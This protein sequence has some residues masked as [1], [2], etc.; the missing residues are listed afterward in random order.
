MNED[1]KREERNLEILI[2]AFLTSLS[3]FLASIYNI[4]L[5]GYPFYRHF[6]YLPAALSTFWWG[7]RGLIVPIIISSFV[8]FISIVQHYPVEKFLSVI[9]ESMLLLIVSLLVSVLSEE[10]NRAL[11]KEREFKLM[12]AH[13]FFN[14]ICIAE[15][16]LDMVLKEVPPSTREKLENVRIAVQR[17][18]KVVKNVV[19]KGEIRE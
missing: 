12:T 5:E 11:E 10:K 9:I 14:P 19:E 13:Y 3:I 17:I 4:R 7:R 1:E 16:F 8:I 15:G 6:F 18:K 2:V